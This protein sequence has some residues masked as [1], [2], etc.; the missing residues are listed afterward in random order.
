MSKYRPAAS[1][2]DLKPESAAAPPRDPVVTPFVPSDSEN[3]GFFPA[4]VVD[5]LM[6]VVIDLGAEYW[7]LRRRLF[8]LEKALE[9]SGALT[10]DAVERYEPTQSD[11]EAWEQE[12]DIF[13]RRAFGALARTGQY[14][15]PN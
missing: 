3:F 6:H 12:R 10:L 4:Q 15:A 11:R 7:T 14:K 13:I 1:A 5:N 8:V 9:Q 2:T